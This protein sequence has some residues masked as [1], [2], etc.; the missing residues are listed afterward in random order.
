M[1]TIFTTEWE[2]YSTDE[3]VEEKVVVKPVKR[4]LA[5]SNGG[6]SAAKG[7][8][9]VPGAGKKRKPGSATGQ[10]DIRSFFTKK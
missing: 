5:P 10:K 2:E 6:D 9:A 4:V 7:K 3:E 8:K 1:K